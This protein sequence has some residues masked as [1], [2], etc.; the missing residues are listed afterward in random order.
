MTRVM[1]EHYK[2]R[3]SLISSSTL[4]DNFASRFLE[5]IIELE[6]VTML[7]QSNIPESVSYSPKSKILIIHSH[8]WSVFIRLTSTPT[9]HFYQICHP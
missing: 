5:D 1:E 6:R 3:E 2:N 9:I 7:H 4:H 8:K